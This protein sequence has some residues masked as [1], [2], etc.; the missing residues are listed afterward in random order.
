MNKKNIM[1]NILGFNNISYSQRGEDIIIYNYLKYNCKLDSFFYI[2]IGCFDPIKYSNTYYLYKRNGKG[3]CI[4]PQKKFAKKFKKKRPKDLFIN[5]SISNKKQETLY[6][7]KHNIITTTSEDEKNIYEKLGYK[8]KKVEPVNSIDINSILAMA[9][10]KI[11]FIN[12]DCE[13]SEFEI[14][15]DINFD[16]YKPLIICIETIDPI[17]SNK[18]KIYNK[19]VKFMRKNNYEILADTIVNTIFIKK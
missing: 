17:T 8:L 1:R 19:I 10:Q 16:K 13:G 6:L 2:D 11:D 15:K 18:S 7:F 12:I 5:K 3:I 9:N 4:D 14:L